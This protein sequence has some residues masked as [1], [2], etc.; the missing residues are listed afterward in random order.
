MNQKK[1]VVTVP[2]MREIYGRLLQRPAPSPQRI[3]QVVSE[4][5]RR[6]EEARIYH[7]RSRTGRFPPLHCRCDS[8]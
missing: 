8:G 6:N 5:L 2:Q 4:V 1:A 7:W 3:A